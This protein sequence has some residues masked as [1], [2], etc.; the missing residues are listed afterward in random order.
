[1]PWEANQLYEFGPFQADSVR[2]LLCREGQP[3]PLTSKA[4]DTL[5][6]LIRN[7]DRVMGKE[8]L[9]KAIWP[10]SF[11]EEANLA[12]NVSTLRKALGDQ[13]GEHLY[14]ATVPGRGYRFVGAVRPPAEPAAEIVVGSRTTAEVVIEEELDDNPPRR[15]RLGTV[16][17][18]GL[19]AVVLAGGFLWSRRDPP[20]PDPGTLRSLAVLPFQQLTPASGEEYLGLGLTD[21]AIT[22]LSNIRQL[23]V[24]P[25][26]SVLKYAGPA[27]DLRIPGRE[28]GVE[29]ILDGKLQKSGDRLRLTVQLIRV[30]DGRPLWAETFDENFTGIF[31]VEDSVSQRVAQTLAIRL[32]QPEKQQLA[33]HYTE[34]LEAYRNYLQGRYAYCRFTP[35]GLNQA[36]EY[37][38]RAIAIDPG[39]A[40][41]YAGLAD[42]YTTASDW[43]LAPREALPK[44]EAAARKALAFDDNLADAHSSLAHALMHEWKLTASGSEFQVAL[45]LNPHNTS[46]YFA[47]GEY[48]SALGRYDEAV[49]QLNKALE[50]DPLSPEIVAF[51]RLAALLETRLPTRLLRRAGGQPDGPGILAAAHG[52]RPFISVHA[53]VSRG[54][55]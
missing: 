7:R 45:A 36:I 14:I 19:L 41:A 53:P 38:N 8:E 51:N 23:V 44:A 25:T 26:S 55:F 43:V 50:I 37:F 47:Y 39:D 33:R 46:T 35:Q 4:F 52:G 34:N 42:A 31:A 22:R 27:A 40:L 21:A 15:V 30:K 49:A 48:L 9:L 28:L 1:M 20:A 29:A 13:P 12:Q 24:R 18:L 32:A 11:V 3:V 5:L 17:G 16:A 54:D 6:V 10:D 2:R